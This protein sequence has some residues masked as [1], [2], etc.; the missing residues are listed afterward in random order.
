VLGQQLERFVS[1]DSKLCGNLL[2]MLVTEGGSELI[3]R[4]LQIS[5][6]AKP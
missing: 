4:D 6:V 3:G 1:R 2:D 5:A